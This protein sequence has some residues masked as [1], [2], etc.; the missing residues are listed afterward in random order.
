MIV[1]TSWLPFGVMGLTIFPFVFIKPK[2]D[3]CL[4]HER[5][6]YEQQRRWALYG[7]GVGLL[8]WFAL[9]LFALPAYFNPWRRK[10]ETEAYEAEGYGPAAIRR[11]LRREPYWLL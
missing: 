7:L 2:A 6:H 10:W 9:Y 4:V 8:V 11:L 5:V 3:W 1:R